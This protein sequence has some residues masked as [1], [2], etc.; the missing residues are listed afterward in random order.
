MTPPLWQKQRGT[1]EPLDEGERK[2]K[3]WVKTQHS[4]NEDHGIWSQHFMANRWG[5]METLTGFIFLGSKITADGDC[6]HEIKRQL[7]L[8][9]KAMT[10]LDSALKSRDITLLTRVAIVKPM[11]F[12]VVKYGC[13]SWTTKKAGCQSCDAFES[14]GEESWES[15]I[16]QG[17]QTCQSWWK[18]ILNIHGKDWCWISNTLATWCEWPTHWKGPWCWESLKAGIER[19]DRGWDNAWH[20]QFNIHEF[21]QTLGDS[22]GPRS[23][24]CCSPWGCKESDTAKPLNT[25][26]MFSWE[27]CF[28][29]YLIS[30]FIFI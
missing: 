14:A 18:W 7:L 15:L 21:E 19:E 10:N 30:S 5:K 9:R 6:S 24:A 28:T 29:S 20:H 3:S 2:W 27:T 22:E 26:H 13:E 1:K 17:N 11:V 16:W 25:S 4:N 12:P 8:G 23:L